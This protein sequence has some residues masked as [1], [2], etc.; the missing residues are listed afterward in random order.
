MS[1]Q[2]FDLGSEI[3]VAESAGEDVQTLGANGP[4]EAFRNR[5]RCRRFQFERG[6]GQLH[7]PGINYQSGPTFG[8]VTDIVPPRNI[9]FGVSF[10]FLT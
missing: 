10:E 9:R 2:G 3:A 4:D 7:R 8:Y 6:V 5:V 1:E